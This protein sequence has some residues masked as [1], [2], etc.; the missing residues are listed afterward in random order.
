MSLSNDLLLY[1]S[2][3]LK[4][5]GAKAVKIENPQPSNGLSRKSVRQRFLEGLGIRIGPWKD[6]ILKEA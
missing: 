3:E 5:L 1:R 2:S 6:T 4:G